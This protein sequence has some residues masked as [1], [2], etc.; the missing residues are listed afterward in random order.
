MIRRQKHAIT[1]DKKTVLVVVDMQD[2]SF[3]AA[4]CNTTAQNILK[5]IRLAKAADSFD[6]AGADE[7]PQRS[8]SHAGL[9][10]GEA[11]ISVVAGS[12]HGVAGHGGSDENI[13][14]AGV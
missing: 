14:R 10:K 9:S 12:L 2:E 1:F 11:R 5:L 13:A 7:E 6:P 4:K 8:G 3:E